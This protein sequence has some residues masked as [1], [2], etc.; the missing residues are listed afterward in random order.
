MALNAERGEGILDQGQLRGR[1]GVGKVA[2][3][4]TKLG[5]GRARFH[6]THNI[7]EPRTARWFQSVQIV[8]GDKC[9]I[10][11]GRRVGAAETTGPKPERKQCTRAG[12]RGKAEPLAASEAVAT[13]FVE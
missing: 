5:H 13:W 1:A 8:Y 7:V 12:A 6:L 4:K 9:E 11:T 2:A 3:E 10:I